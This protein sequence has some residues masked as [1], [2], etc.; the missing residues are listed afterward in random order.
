MKYGG[1]GSEIG[2]D[3]IEDRTSSSEVV[4]KQVTGKFE[5]YVVVRLLLVIR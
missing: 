4:W 3:L 1:V 5:M 2:V